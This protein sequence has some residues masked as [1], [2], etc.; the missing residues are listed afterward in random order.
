MRIC[1]IFLLCVFGLCFF[2]NAAAGLDDGLIAHYPFDS[3]ANDISGNGNHAVESG[4][5]TYVAGKNNQSA[6]FDGENDFI[7]L[8]SIDNIG[9]VEG[10]I[11]LWVK[12]KNGFSSGR[13]NMNLFSKD[14]APYEKNTI[15]ILFDGST[16][17]IM[18]DYGDYGDA[19]YSNSNV[20]SEDWYHVAFSWGD[21][22]LKMYIN[23]EKQKD[24][25]NI[26]SL[27]YPPP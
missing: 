26:I 4:G 9:F 12:V 25:L 6:S 3:N 21:V 19:I 10:T 5:I 8:P 15:E 1:N 13:T 18:L 11:T 2:G 23:A 24:T 27:V 14:N 20:W 16:G 17:T 22:G 7:H